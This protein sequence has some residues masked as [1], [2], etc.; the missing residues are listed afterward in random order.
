VSFWGGRRVLVTGHTGFKGSWLALWLHAAGAEVTGFADAPPTAPSLFELARVGELVRDLRGDVRDP[1]AVRRATAGADVVFHLAAQPIVR[2]SLEDPAGTLAVNVLGAAHVLDAARDAVCVC[3]TSDKC[4]APA[5]G[6]PHTERDPLG[7][8]DPYSASKAAQE[9]V[10]AAYRESFG[11]RVA[12]ARA[13]N[14]IG[15]GDW[16]RDRLVPDLARAAADGA[17]VVVRQPDAVRPWQHVLNP[18]SGYLL[19]AERLAGS[20]EWACA[21]NFG[22][23]A[24]DARPVRWI[25]ERLAARWPLDVR[26]VDA[27]ASVESPAVRLDA[28]AARE[29][30]GWAPRW[31]LEAGLDATVAWYDG[32]RRGEDARALSLAQIEAFTAVPAG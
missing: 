23:A 12:T 20:A 16:A 13:G 10:A 30:L 15:G 4:Y 7:G 31:D 9:L 18:L 5:G 27:G 22:P 3:V 8:P 28:S 19:L 24:D 26:V 32:V 21:W 14:V 25:V 17:P 29:R 1:E 2:T 11:V 6:R